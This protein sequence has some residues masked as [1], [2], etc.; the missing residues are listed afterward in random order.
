MISTGID[1]IVLNLGLGLHHQQDDVD[2]AHRSIKAIILNAPL[3][4]TQREVALEKIDEA[5]RTVIEGA[6]YDDCMMDIRAKATMAPER[7]TTT[8]KRTRLMP[9][10]TPTVDAHASNQGLRDGEMKQMLKWATAKLCTYNDPCMGLG[11]CLPK[12]ET[13]PAKTRVFIFGGA[14]MHYDEL[15][16]NAIEV[17]DRAEAAS[18]HRRD[19]ITPYRGEVFC[20]V[21]NY[22]MSYM[23]AHDM[24]N[25]VAVVD[26]RPLVEAYQMGDNNENDTHLAGLMNHSNSPNCVINKRTFDGVPDVLCVETLRDIDAT[27]AAVPLTLMYSVDTIA[28]PCRSSGKPWE[29]YDVSVEEATKLMSYGCHKRGIDSP[30]I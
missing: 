27:M 3:E 7:A 6:W 24:R 17:A 26:P 11:V 16:R 13:L 9:A 28:L 21:Y 10:S 5:K 18:W 1:S 22:C 20:S 23:H 8:S 2:E 19:K 25:N 29:T 14:L 15:K 30:E 12:G 4:H